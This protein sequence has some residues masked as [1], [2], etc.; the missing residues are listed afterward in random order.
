MPYGSLLNCLGIQPIFHENGKIEQSY[1]GFV[2]RI[3]TSS[4]PEGFMKY[5]IASRIGNE[6]DVII[7]NKFHISRQNE[8]IVNFLKN[9]SFTLKHNASLDELMQNH[10][11]LKETLHYHLKRIELYISLGCG[12]F[13]ITSRDDLYNEKLFLNTEIRDFQ[14][15]LV[16]ENLLP[17]NV[18]IL[19]CKGKTSFS[20]PYVAC[21]LI[22]KS[23]F[24]E[25]CYLNN[26]DISSFIFDRKARY[27][28]YEKQMN[29]YSLYQS[30]LD[31]IEVPYW[32]IE[33]FNEPT[34]PRQKAYYTT[35]YFD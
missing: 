8:V 7:E 20:N 31:N 27:P 1:I 29:L 28:I 5:H 19:G 9:N 34:T 13:I 25:L 30:Y 24:D 4:T 35:L 17:K 21:P 23:H 14:V 2:N 22:D 15:Y 26:I 10:N 11:L 6:N 32:Y 16:N 33:K 18:L 12:N 3:A